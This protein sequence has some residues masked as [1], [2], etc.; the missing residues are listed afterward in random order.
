MFNKKLLIFGLPFAI[1]VTA[2]FAIF[3]NGCGK[4]TVVVDDTPKIEYS[5]TALAAE[6]AIKAY[7]ANVAAN[8]KKLSEQEYTTVTDIMEKNVNYDK[9]AR[10]KYASDLKAILS[11][12]L[13]DADVPKEQ[14]KRLF[15]EM[16][17]GFEKA[18]K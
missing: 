6:K 3:S 2:T 1:A 17:K 10:E 18:S 16:S 8:Y 15:D 7:A 4:D 5:E 11:P 14:A 12:V 9:V 13:G